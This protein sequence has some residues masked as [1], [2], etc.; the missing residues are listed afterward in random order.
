MAFK[1]IGFG[2]TIDIKKEENGVVEGAYLGAKKIVTQLGEQFIYRFKK[3]NGDV[4]GC[5]GF[6]ALNSK[7]EN[8]AKGSYCRV[9]YTG[10]KEIETKFG[11][12]PVHQCKVEVDNER[13]T[14][15]EDDDMDNI[16]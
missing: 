9:T 3:D 11:T 16:V 1:E 13:S 10:M 5:Y 6:T 7:I 12:K 2:D 4:V 14:N 15:V 8:V